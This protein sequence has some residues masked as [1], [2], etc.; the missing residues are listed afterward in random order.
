MSPEEMKMMAAW[1]EHSTP[2][3]HHGHLKFFEGKWKY[4]AKMYP[5]EGAPPME[6]AGTVEAKLDM[7]GRF[8]VSHWQ[9]P[10]PFTPEPFSGMEVLGYDNAKKQYVSTWIDN[11]T[12]STATAIGTCNESGKVFTYDGGMYDPSKGAK[13][14]T[15][16]VITVVNDNKY[17]FKM[18]EKHADKKEHLHMDFTVT[19][20]G[21]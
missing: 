12:T 6:I 8:L 20:A 21:G 18:Y 5:A 16:T 13:T 1:M 19:R 17:T 2:G 10:S 11:M 14:P 7:G 15:R 9:G 3:K 4:T